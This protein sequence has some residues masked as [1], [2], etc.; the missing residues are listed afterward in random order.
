MKIVYCIPHL[1]NS[2]G[3]E[4]VLTQKANYLAQEPD[5]EILIVTTESTPEGKSISYF[6]LD[7]KIRIVEL[8]INFNEDFTLPLVRKYY[9]HQTKQRQYKKALL[10]LLHQEHADICISMCGKEIEWLGKQDLP[11]RKIA[12]IHF[13]M[14]YREQLF[15]QYH[16]GAIAK[17]T[18]KWLTGRL[19]H[20]VRQMDTLVTLTKADMASWM[21]AGVRNVCCIPNPCS[22]LPSNSGKHEQKQVLAVGRLHPQKGFDMLLDAW[23]QISPSAPDW[24]LRIVGEGDCRPNLEQQ[25]SR[26]GLQQTVRMDGVSADIQSEYQESRIF[27]LSSRWEGLPLA[28]IE[29]MSQGT[30]CVAFDCPQGPKELIA[31]GVSGRLVKNGDISELT[32]KIKEQMNDPEGSAAMGAQAYQYVQ[33]HLATDPI[34][35]QWKDLLR[36]TCN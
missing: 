24:V 23:K 20:H 36:L 32:R 8:G 15:L 12:E 28:L 34:M 7:K 1:Y 3:M 17:M 9:R 31:D 2:G 10:T 25:I 27:V 14:D 19:I 16:S 13:A 29:A 6:P 18:G 4:R 11:C 5:T 35:A 26:L 22:I 30:C 33:T 21:K